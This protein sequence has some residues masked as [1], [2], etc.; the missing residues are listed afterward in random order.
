MIHPSRWSLQRSRPGQDEASGRGLGPGRHP[1]HFLQGGRT[2]PG[3]QPCRSDPG[4]G[5]APSPARGVPAASGAERRPRHRVTFTGGSPGGGG[6][7]ARSEAGRSRRGEA[8]SDNRTEPPG[9]ATRPAARR[10]RAAPGEARRFPQSQPS[11]ASLT[12]TVT[13]PTG[14]SEERHRG[15]GGRRPG[16]A[17]LSL[18]VPLRSLRRAERSA[19]RRRAALKY[20]PA[21]CGA[22]TAAPSLAAPGATPRPYWLR[23]SAA[24]RPGPSAR[25]ALPTSCFI[26]QCR[27]R[28]RGAGRGQRRGGAGRGRP[29]SVRGGV[30]PRRPRWG[31]LDL[32]RL[33][34]HLIPPGIRHAPGGTP[35]AAEGCCWAQRPGALRRDWPSAP[36]AF[37]SLSSGRCGC[38]L[39]TGLKAPSINAL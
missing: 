22:L 31:S 20:R 23:R 28:A 17:R 24:R 13:G 29:L 21:R 12:F 4:R 16:P 38:A 30:G 37:C 1:K 35:C 18:P 14:E 32:N 3:S 9:S 8:A 34:G 33:L 36:W 39:V 15:G 5:A 19:L 6:D 2:R 7:L 26:P 27:A 11:G 25:A 10:D